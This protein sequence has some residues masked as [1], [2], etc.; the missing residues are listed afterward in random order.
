M[1]IHS[2]KYYPFK[3]LFLQIL[4]AELRVSTIQMH[5]T[6]SKTEN[7]QTAVRLIRD[8]VQ[9]YQPRLVVL[10][11]NFTTLYGR[12]YFVQHA[13]LIPTGETFT[14]MSQLAKELQ[15]YLVAGSI[16]ECDAQ[17]KTLLYN[18]TMVFA[19]TGALITKYRK[20]HLFDSELRGEPR[21]L[22]TEFMRAGHELG[23]FE[24]DGVKIGLGIGYDLAF[25]E[26]TH[27]YRR[28]DVKMMVYVASFPTYLGYAQWEQLLRTRAIDDQLCV[29]G[30]A[31]VR[32]DMHPELISYAHSLLIDFRGRVLRRAVDFETVLGAEFDLYFM[33]TYR[34]QMNVWK[35]KRADMYETKWL[36]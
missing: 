26:L 14:L 7:L 15:I 30:A 29:V 36:L 8:A 16:P 22:Q 21:M 18:T 19:P 23:I 9:R 32:D 1:K 6:A 25:A 12:Q 33:D 34:Q 2:T 35:Q 20:I 28:K 5:V 11:E 27:L 3:I 10:P 24:I 13:E 31:T 17:N 4:G